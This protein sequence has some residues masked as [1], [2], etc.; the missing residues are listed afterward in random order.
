MNRLIRDQQRHDYDS[1]E[2]NESKGGNAIDPMAAQV[3]IPQARVKPQQW[4]SFR[5]RSSLLGAR[6][7]ACS[8]LGIRCGYER[9]GD[10]F[11]VFVIPGVVDRAHVEL[12][13]AGAALCSKAQQLTRTDRHEKDMAGHADAIN[14]Y[15]ADRLASQFSATKP[16]L[17]FVWRVPQ[18]ICFQSLSTGAAPHESALERDF[19]TLTSFLEP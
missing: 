19:V 6:G 17:R 4:V 9:F 1:N 18:T 13:G 14:T 5:D 12:P 11:W 16:S 8:E 15:C 3:A 10:R 2:S 7:G